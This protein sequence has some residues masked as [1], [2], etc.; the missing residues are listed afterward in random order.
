[1]SPLHS[2]I[3]TLTVPAEFSVL[4]V[5]FVMIAYHFILSSSHRTHFITSH[6]IVE[7]SHHCIIL[8]S[9]MFCQFFWQINILSS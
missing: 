2:L 9:L 8:T 3:L 4:T 6:V 5:A 7:P 1:M